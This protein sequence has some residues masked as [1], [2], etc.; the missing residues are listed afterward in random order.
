LTAI[1]DVREL[2]GQKNEKDPG[3]EAVSQGQVQGIARSPS[4]SV[5]PS[6]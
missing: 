2:L 1:D 3:H 6:N 4:Q 5:P